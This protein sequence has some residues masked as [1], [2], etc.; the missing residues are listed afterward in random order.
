[1]AARED[2]KTA[3]KSGRT[4]VNKGKPPDLDAFLA[5]KAHPLEGE[6]HQVRK[7]ILGLSPSIREE[8]KWN[9]ISFRNESD[10]F[11]TVHLRAQS[12][13]QLILFTGVKKKPTAETGVPVEDPAA[14][15]EK[16]LAKDRCLVSLGAGNAF[17]ANRAAL[18][19]LVKVWIRS[20]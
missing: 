13:V 20:V 4:T 3:P 12:T 10:F 9:S 2:K 19:T 1:M 16:W 14:I 11:A 18:A 6:I 7:L 15:I 8:I 5:S 17:K